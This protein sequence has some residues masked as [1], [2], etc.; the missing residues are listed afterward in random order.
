MCAID[1]S[2]TLQL[3]RVLDHTKSAWRLIVLLQNH[4]PMS[5]IVYAYQQSHECK[6]GEVEWRDEDLI[7]IFT[8][9]MGA[10]AVAH[11]LQILVSIICGIVAR[12]SIH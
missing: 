9:A 1:I 8:T 11:D 6:Q 2:Q 5:V 10:A 4:K 12:A 3:V 7:G